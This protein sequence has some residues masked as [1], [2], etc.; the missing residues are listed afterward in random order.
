MNKNTNSSFYI[1]RILNSPTFIHKEVQRNLLNFLYKAAQ[2]GK[3]LREMD[4]AFDF[5]KRDTTFQPGDDTIVRVS[6][7]KLRA[8]L[9]QYYQNEG[10]KDELV[11]ELPK[12][13]YS[14]KAVKKGEETS[15]RIKKPDWK[16]M[17]YLFLILSVALNL[18]LFLRFE[19]RPSAKS[20]PV[21]SD[22]LQSKLPVY[23]TLGDPFFF[24]ATNDSSNESIVVRDISVNSAQDLQKQN[25]ARFFNRKMKIGNLDYSYLST[26]NVRPLPDIISIFSRAN[27]EIR[28]QTLSETNIEDI[29]R[30][31]QVFIGN[32][33]SFG[34]FTKF[35]EKTSIRLHTHPREIV[36]NKGADS[37]VLS[38]PEKI[39]GYYI[40]YAFMV[41][42]PGMNNTIISMMGDFHA[43]GIKGLSNCIT[44]QSSITK[45]EKDVSGKYGKF[46]EYFE[47]V[48]KVTSYNYFDFKTEVIYFNPLAFN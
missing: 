44:E 1:E 36:I 26:N 23:I 32:I 5:F 37:L 20:N 35:L 47:M 46:P 16:R 6:I 12:G 25:T 31:N 43:S 15:K 27:I 9:D 3:I 4:I 28:L 18:F 34:F 38:V 19:L 8:L 30:N 11:F 21:W 17:V 7:Y 29:K 2:E 42:V 24:R 13:Y 10:Q 39:Q 22:L 41:K 40:D 48:V 33:N 14:L 45:L